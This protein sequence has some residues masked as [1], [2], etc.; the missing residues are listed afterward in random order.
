MRKAAVLFVSVVNERAVISIAF[1]ITSAY[2]PGHIARGRFSP[3]AVGTP[4]SIFCSAFTTCLEEKRCL[5]STR[6]L[7]S[8]G[9]NLITGSFKIKEWYL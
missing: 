2:P 9:Q 3:V 7:A 8:G 1:G 4:I 5:S 6:R